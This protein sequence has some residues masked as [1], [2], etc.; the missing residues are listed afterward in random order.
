MELT[1]VKITLDVLFL[2]NAL[3]FSG[4]LNSIN[5]VAGRRM[6]FPTLLNIIR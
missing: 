2:K 3:Q 5:D 6:A 1:M 4:D